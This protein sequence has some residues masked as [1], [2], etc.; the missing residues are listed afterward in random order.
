MSD[1]YKI[2]K[3]DDPYFVVFTVDDWLKVLSRARVTYVRKQGNG[4]EFKT[5]SILFD[6]KIPEYIFSK[7]AL[8]Q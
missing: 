4:T 7:A 6:Q 5:T 1:K 2:F 3:S 8:K